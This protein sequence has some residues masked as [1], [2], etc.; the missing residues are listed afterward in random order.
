[1]NRR[2][3]K[4]ER[5]VLFAL[6]EDGSRTNADVADRIGMRE[7]TVSIHKRHLIRNGYVHFVNFPAFHR[8]GFQMMAEIFL[9]VNPV[10][11]L[12]R[13]A[14]AYGEFFNTTPWVFDAYAATGFITASGVFASVSDVIKLR[15]QYET[16]F[17]DSPGLKGR[18]RIW[19]F[20]FDISR[21]R[22]AGNFAPG[23]HRMLDI[24]GLEPVTIPP[25]RFEVKTAPVS[26]AEATILVNLVE[27][28]NATD[29][30]VA[31]KMRRSR[32]S[33]NDARH[34]ILEKGLYTRVAVPTL[35]S[36]ESGVSAAAYLKF[37]STAT[38]EKKVTVAGDEWWTQSSYFLERDSRL[39]ACY[40]FKDL[41]ECRSLMDKFVS[42]FAEADLLTE[43]PEIFLA[44][45]GDTAT[46]LD[47]S[48]ASILRTRG[49]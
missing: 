30:E 33:V 39:L 3:T 1:M 29:A 48:F 46:L 26:Q 41:K 19:L 4:Q 23:L 17:Q 18:M 43:S 35:I 36:R 16:F 32:Q 13:L 47:C 37:R 22:Y 15:D 27:N 20:P 2:L 40:W 44:P 14:K 8:L 45:H 38:F 9:Q 7:S 49:I 11:P 28:P 21:C 25:E 12:N 42:P 6:V 31:H 34:S 10:V 5:L 24:E